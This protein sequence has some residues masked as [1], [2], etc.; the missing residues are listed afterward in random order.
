MTMYMLQ[1]TWNISVT[2]D[3]VYVTNDRI[4]LSQMTMYMLQMTWNISVTNDHVYVANEIEYL[5]H[6]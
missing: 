1:M 6:K 2:N 3:H 4:S 5:C